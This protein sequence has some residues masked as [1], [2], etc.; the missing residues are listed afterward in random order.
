MTVRSCV[1]YVASSVGFV[2]EPH[3]NLLNSTLKPCKP[4]TQSSPLSVPGFQATSKSWSPARCG[5]STQSPQQTN[6]PMTSQSSWP[7]SSGGSP[8]STCPDWTCQSQRR[9]E[10]SLPSTNFIR[11][12]KKHLNLRKCKRS[13]L[14]PSFGR[15]SSRDSSTFCLSSS[16]H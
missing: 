3:K 5:P 12:T 16:C 8:P 9:T 13:R 1:R 15:P 6:T 11:V 14:P 10:K 2:A 7:T 4:Q